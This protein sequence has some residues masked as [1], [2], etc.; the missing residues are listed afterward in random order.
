VKRPT[1]SSKRNGPSLASGCA[2]NLFYFANY[3]DM[4]LPSW[5]IYTVIRRIA[6]SNGAARGPTVVRLMALIYVRCRHV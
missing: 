6:P 2:R 5:L 1:E 3:I 4:V